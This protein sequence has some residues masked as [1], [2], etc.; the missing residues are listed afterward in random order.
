MVLLVWRLR[1]GLLRLSWSLAL[2]G[3]LFHRHVCVCLGLGKLSA[4][5]PSNSTSKAGR[6]AGPGCNTSSFP[7]LLPGPP[8]ST[9]GQQPQRSWA[10]CDLMFALQSLSLC[11]MDPSGLFALSMQLGGKRRCLGQATLLTSF[12]TVCKAPDQTTQMVLNGHEEPLDSG[13]LLCLLS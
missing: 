2:S 6:G 13:L 8:P 5:N 4:L 10:S 1:G 9:W 3:A 12:S 7:L 11:L